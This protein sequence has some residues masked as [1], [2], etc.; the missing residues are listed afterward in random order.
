MSR[1]EKKTM[2][3]LLTI[4]VLV[5]VILYTAPV[6][7]QKPYALVNGI[8]TGTSEGDAEGSWRYKF[9]WDRGYGLDIC[10]VEHTEEGVQQRRLETVWS[11]TGF[12]WDDGPFHH[13]ARM[14]QTS[15]GEEC[16]V[17]AFAWGDSQEFEV[18]ILPDS[19]ENYELYLIAFGLDRN[20]EVLLGFI[21]GVIDSS[22]YVIYGETKHAAFY[23]SLPPWEPGA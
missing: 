13:V 21:K 4:L 3:T 7:A 17:Y 12:F 20:E 1:L 15:R 6:S 22:E 10:I 11:D 18:A 2:A 19:T 23:P 14:T 9:I 8:V 16:T 5:S